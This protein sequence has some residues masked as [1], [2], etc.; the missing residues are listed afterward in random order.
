MAPPEATAGRIHREGTARDTAAAPD[1]VRRG[2]P[3]DAVLPALAREDAP[4]GDA[5]NEFRRIPL[6]PIADP[7]GRPAQNAAGPPLAQPGM[8]DFARPPK[9]KAPGRPLLDAGKG[10]DLARKLLATGPRGR[11]RFMPET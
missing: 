2:K 8:P 3:E 4:R 7:L 6:D 10:D 5:V 11:G 1:G 9:S